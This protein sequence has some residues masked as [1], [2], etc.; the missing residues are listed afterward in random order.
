V[1]LFKIYI[2][3]WVKVKQTVKQNSFKKGG[4]EKVEMTSLSSLSLVETII[5]PIFN[6]ILKIK[7]MR[8]TKKQNYAS[9][10][11]ILVFI[12]FF[13]REHYLRYFRTLNINTS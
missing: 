3:F 11:N 6:P 4:K 10:N 1:N 8:G 9:T 5:K 7:K 13:L 12:C 2:S